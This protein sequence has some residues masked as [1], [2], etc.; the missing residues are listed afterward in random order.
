MGSL[1]V[2]MGCLFQTVVAGFRWNQWQRSPEMGGRLAMASAVA[3]VGTRW[4]CRRGIKGRS[5]LEAV[6]ALP[7]NTQDPWAPQRVWRDLAATP[8]QMLDLD[9]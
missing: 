4:Q 5:H 7:W 9:R 2:A 1:S 6:A 3:F 8:H